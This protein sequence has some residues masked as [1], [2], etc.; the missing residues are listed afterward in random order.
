MTMPGDIRQEEASMPATPNPNPQNNNPSTAENHKALVQ[1]YRE[2]AS[3][4]GAQEADARLAAASNQMVIQQQLN[5]VDQEAYRDLFGAG[6]GEGY[7]SDELV[8]TV[9]ATAVEREG[10]G[11][12][13]ARNRYVQLY[14]AAAAAA[15]PRDGKVDGDEKCLLDLS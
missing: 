15:G 4:G 11:G 1:R 10:Q 6:E 14:S 7:G 2:Y 13:P 5:R 12:G 8:R 3:G 9:S